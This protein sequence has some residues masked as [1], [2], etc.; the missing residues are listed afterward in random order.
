[1]TVLVD[2]SVWVSHF[3]Q[4]NEALVQLLEAGMVMCHPNV[5]IEIACGTPPSR[6][7]VIGML[8]ALNSAC[9]ATHE[10]VLELIERHA[11]YGRGVGLVDVSLL[12]AALLSDHTLLWTL[13]RRLEMLA[14]ELGRAY[15]PG[16][17]L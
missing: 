13:D 6:R 12:A 7:A 10:E 11:L 14:A 9:V 3:K 15:M 2:T 4:R 1:M 5:V 8:A 16:P 17:R